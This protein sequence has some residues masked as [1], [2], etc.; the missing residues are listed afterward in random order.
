MIAPLVIAGAGATATPALA[1]AVPWMEQAL[2]VGVAAAR[3]AFAFVL[4]PVFS[5][6]IIPS[7]V[8][9]SII[10]AFG[11]IALSL[12]HPFSPQSLT[13]GEWLWLYA[14][15]AVAGVTIGFFFGTVI[16]AM[17][18]AGEII[19][20]KVGATIGQI[21]DPMSG[22]QESLTAGLLNRFAQLVF[23]SAGGITLLV[24]TVMLSYAAWPLGPGP[25][26][27]EPGA[28]TL[29]EREFG[30]LFALA[31]I[32]AS[33]VLLVL[34]VIDLGM[35]LLNRFAQQFN[36]FSLSM[37]IKAVAATLV[38]IMILP[39]LADAVVHDLSTREY[40]AAGVLKRTGRAGPP[41]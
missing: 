24:G 4:V 36:V 2:T 18:A 38:L 30:R 12:P 17:G 29:F 37:S 3:F 25:M 27:F 16:W 14:K 40:T 21:V 22:M 10:V 15:E 9:N 32:F 1:Q 5:P 19:D 26:R 8:R 39:L 11:L 7:T 31:F 28:I 33:P 13:A 41:Q 35:G 6:Q 23:V 34:Y 20:T